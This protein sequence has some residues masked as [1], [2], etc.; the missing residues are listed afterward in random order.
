MGPQNPGQK[1]P[2]P[3]PYTNAGAN[4]GKNAPEGI[5]KGSGHLMYPLQQVTLASLA[6]QYSFAQSMLATRESSVR[7]RQARCYAGSVLALIC[8]RLDVTVM[9]EM[10]FICS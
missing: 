3:L 2:V 10:R 9:P 7:A 5:K 4:L 8:P 6:I 1:T